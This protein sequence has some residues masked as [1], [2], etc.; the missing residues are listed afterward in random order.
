MVDF[1]GFE[2]HPVDLPDA[3]EMPLHAD[4]GERLRGA[5]IQFRGEV[6]GPESVAFDPRGRGP[7]TGIADGR[8][9]V[10]DGARSA[11]LAHASP[12]W[13]VDLCGGP[14][15][16]PTEYLRDEHVCGCALGI[17]F[18]KRTGDLYIADTYF[19]LSKVGPEGR[20]AICVLYISIASLVGAPSLQDYGIIG[21]G[22]PLV[23]Y[24]TSYIYHPLN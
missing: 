8:V 19:G 4:A 17:R 20:L 12:S 10:W 1:P 2:A 16:F 21:A 18:D 7:Y 3:V 24:F 13:T 9:L 6:R 14:K 5:E 22:R 23:G 11:Y 15:A